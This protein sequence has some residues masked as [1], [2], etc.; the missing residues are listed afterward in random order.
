MAKEKITAI[1][2]IMPKFLKSACPTADNKTYQETEVEQFIRWQFHFLTLLSNEFNKFVSSLDITTIKDLKN[3]KSRFITL[4]L[5]RLL[6]IIYSRAQSTL[7]INNNIFEVLTALQTVGTD[8]SLIKLFKIFLGVDIEIT[9][10]E[11]G[12]VQLELLGKIQTKMYK[13]IVPSRANGYPFVIDGKLYYRMEDCD[14][15]ATNVIKRRFTKILFK[16]RIDENQPV[17]RKFWGLMVYPEGYEHA[18][19]SFLRKFI[20]IGRVLKVKTVDGNMVIND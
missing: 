8:E 11:A 15:S 18:F 16:H 4:W 12:V 3:I 7:D 1:H 2:K 14:Q 6:Q 9:A 13:Y 10:P 19:Y 17:A 20:P 5:A